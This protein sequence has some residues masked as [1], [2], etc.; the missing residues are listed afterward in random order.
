MGTNNVFSKMAAHLTETFY[1]PDKNFYLLPH[2]M[3]VNLFSLQPNRPCLTFSAR[4][5][6]NGEILETKVQP[7]I[8]RKVHSMSYD[9]INMH[10]KTDYRRTGEI[11]VVGG[12][13]EPDPERPLPKLTKSELHDLKLLQMV[14][15][16][17]FKHRVSKGSLYYDFSEPELEVFYQKGV[18]GLPEQYPH[19][20][21]GHYMSAIRSSNSRQHHSPI[22]LVTF[23]V[24]ERVSA[25]PLFVNV[26]YLP[27]RSLQS[28]PPNA[29][30][31][32]CTVES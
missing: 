19:R 3:S 25:I 10:L 28:G 7:A 13:V 1:S 20:V 18:K 4:L 16:A 2:W 9:E 21:T 23:L 6:S 8:I 5:N 31:L 22:G 26:C 29:T 17:R 32:S 14:A 15:Y 30:F 27:A 12:E 24:A 11:L